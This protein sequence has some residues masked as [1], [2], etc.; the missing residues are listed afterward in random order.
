MKISYKTDYALKAL[1][2]MSINYQGNQKIFKINELSSRLDIPLKYLEAVCVQL[3]NAGF[4]KSKRGKEGGYF[5]SGPPSSFSVGSV[6]RKLEGPIEPIACV[7]AG[8]KG[9]ADT[10]TCVL[11]GV[12]CRLAAAEAELLDSANFQELADDF[13][14]I[15]KI[16]DYTI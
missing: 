4:V 13:L 6:I 5:L 16:T 11:R 1:L 9:C 2:H 15:R 7:Q 8:Y 12:F 3:K 10:E 14:K